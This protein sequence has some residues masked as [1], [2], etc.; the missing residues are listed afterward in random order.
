MA[1]VIVYHHIYNKKFGTLVVGPQIE[2]KA[3]S[4]VFLWLAGGM[5]ALGIGLV[6]ASYV[7]RAVPDLLS[8]AKTLFEVPAANLDL[9]QSEVTQLDIQ[10]LKAPYLPAYDATLPAINHLIIPAIKVNTNLEEATADNYEA[11]LKKGIWRVSDFG[12]PAT[13]TL[14]TILAGHRYGYL[15]WS[16]LY[17]RL[18]SFANL[19]KLKVGDTVEIDYQKRK[20]LYEIYAKT[21]GESITDYGADLILYTCKSITGPT[22]IFAYARLIRV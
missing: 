21:E 4:G 6:I 13:Q 12:S 3:A 1:E 5:A 10:S 9:S 7:P 15:A 17:R 16:D 20:Y 14:P 8:R 11:A 2:S 19:P 18:N 22:R